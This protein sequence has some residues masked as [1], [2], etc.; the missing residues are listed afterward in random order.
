M[1]TL[2]ELQK[3]LEHAREVWPGRR[4]KD[5]F[6]SAPGKWAQSGEIKGELTKMLGVE[7]VRCKGVSTLQPAKGES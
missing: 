6:S 4:W 1:L 3:F 2:R 7:K 5:D